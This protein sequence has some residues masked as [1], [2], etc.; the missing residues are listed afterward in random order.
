M[1]S[2]SEGGPRVCSSDEKE[3][4]DLAQ[5]LGV[6]RPTA[7]TSLEK[8]ES[9]FGRWLPRLLTMARRLV[10]L[11]MHTSG[12]EKLNRPPQEHTVCSTLEL[13]RAAKASPHL[14]F[15]TTRCPAQRVN[16]SRQ[17]DEISEHNQRPQTSRHGRP[18]IPLSFSWSL[19][20][21][22]IGGFQHAPLLQKSTRPTLIVLRSLRGKLLCIFRS[23]TNFNKVVPEKNLCWPGEGARTSCASAR[24]ECPHPLCES[25]HECQCFGSL[26][27]SV[28]RTT[29]PCNQKIEASRLLQCSS[30]RIL[31]L[32]QLMWLDMLTNVKP[33]TLLHSTVFSA[34]VIET[35]CSQHI[36]DQERDSADYDFYE[37]HLLNLRHP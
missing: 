24:H 10:D 37:A 15:Q 7:W 18:R 35:R 27:F 2:Q 3:C 1:L 34:H 8:V 19:G 26:A 25:Q 31:F 6:A 22:L 14:H 20:A 17:Q 5:V 9:D 30:L 4:V 28:I 32:A 29:V 12:P 13:T 23:T 33:E 21:L 11:L 36:H 16:L